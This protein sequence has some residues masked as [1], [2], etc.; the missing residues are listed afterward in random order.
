M[1]SDTYY[2]PMYEIS[3]YEIFADQVLLFDV[4]E[5]VDHG[6][7]STVGSVESD[8]K[9]NFDEAKTV[10]MTQVSRLIPDVVPIH[11]QTSVEILHDGNGR[12]RNHNYTLDGQEYGNNTYIT[13]QAFT[14]TFDNSYKAEVTIT[15]IFYN[16][17]ESLEEIESNSDTALIRDWRIY[18]ITHQDERIRQSTAGQLQSAVSSWY[19]TLRNIA[20]V[21]LL[22]VLV[23][24]G[25]RIIISSTS[26]DKA[27]YKE[28]LGNW[29]VAICLLFIMH[30]IMAFSM[31]IV[32]KITDMITSINF[33]D[34][35]SREIVEQIQSNGTDID[36]VELQ[37]AVAVYLF[38]GTN[39]D[40]TTDRV[41]QA[42]KTLVENT[43][44]GNKDNFKKYFF[45]DKNL[46]TQP[47]D[48][49]GAKVLVWP[50]NNFMEQARMELQ[51]RRNDG[52]PKTV[53]YGYSIIYVVLVIYTL[54]F[55]FTYL[56]RVIYMAF[57][58]IIAPLVAV[59]YP[60]DKMNDGK[61]QAF[62]SWF[63]E[64]IFNLLIQPLHLILYYIL[65]GSA[66]HFA[67]NNI[68]YVVLA[69][70]FFVPAEKLLR[71]FFG[72]E[73]AKTPGI[74][75]GMAGSALMM[76]GLNA[77]M[78]RTP[79]GG[80]A[81]KGNASEN[82]EEEGE[83]K[84]PL[85]NKNFDPTEN[86]AGI[87]DDR[88]NNTNVNEEN[89]ANDTNGNGAN[90]ANDGGFAQNRDSSWTEYEPEY[91]EN[92]ENFG[93]QAQ[94]FYFNNQD[95]ENK[96][97]NTYDPR[98]TQDQVDEL[99][100]EGIKPGDPEYDQY[101]GNYGI[102]PNQAQSQNNRN[103]TGNSPINNDMRRR[104]NNIRRR[105]QAGNAPQNI[106]NNNTQRRMQAGNTNNSANN[107]NTQTP[108]RNRSV[109]RGIKY[110]AKGLDLR[111]R[112][113]Q[114]YMAK[115]AEGKGIGRRA[116]RL[117]GGVVGAT[118]LAT[119]G[120]LIGIT[121]GDPTK[122]AQYMGTAAAGG[123]SLGSRAGDR[124]ADFIARRRAELEDGIKDAKI[125]Y[126]GDE[127]K[128]VEQKKI[129][130]KFKKDEKNL[131]GLE[132]KLKIER[133]EAKKI[134]EEVVPYYLENDI[135]NIDDIV[136]TYK[137][138]R[139]QHLSR[140]K[141]VS[142]AQYAT[143]VMNGEDTNYMTDKRKQEYRDTFIPKFA[144]I[145]DTPEEDVDKVFKYVNTFHKYKK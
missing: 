34:E 20:L 114:R 81:G 121:S 14:F 118:T 4:N 129:E 37:D 85:H 21:A 17:K 69:L 55:C 44:D 19:I 28:M 132:S 26:N 50:A 62:D 53:Q 43:Q 123:Y 112:M 109:I 137:L 7:T 5:V 95:D 136:A 110:G 80:H 16:G 89:G 48:A 24:I 60:I 126:Y 30:Y 72:F 64:Y 117:A 116:L 70:G 139:D 128:N 42:Y 22:S 54:I 133:E 134:M 36:S 65:I 33:Q 18:R 93:W 94:G 142:I 96:S 105:M 59:T 6:H 47:E 58:T 99:K 88:T 12:D 49:N 38:D 1:F 140:D 11:T 82:K 51:I 27:K 79:K 125:G 41:K 127:Y 78:K 71:S 131:R 39:N 52:T 57:L 15:R 101:L 45:T 67:A 100:A 113:H 108:T 8:P 74:F 90:G 138:E 102:R 56:K 68:F 63:K 115:V 75:G 122:A 111:K 9:S 83:Y 144:K 91:P 107:E 23:Y 145:S 103:T 119:A 76:S 66:M 73:K 3:P 77:L 104:I 13:K 84:F 46:T 143:Q 98:L 25:I 31:T 135:T 29:I 120:G 40:G 2:L 130:K 92:P 141:A 106:N 124:G 97:A 87:G 32:N 35:S 10:A 61:A 86:L